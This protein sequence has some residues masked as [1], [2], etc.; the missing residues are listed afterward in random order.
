MK[1]LKAALIVLLIAATQ[2]FATEWKFDKAHTGIGFKVKHM[3]ISTVTGKF[4][5]YDGT[6]KTDGEDF[7]GAKVSFT[8]NINSINTGIEKRD[9]H[10]KSDDFF[11]AK[12]HPKMEFES[13]SF[14][15]LSGNKY[16]L[17]GDLTIRGTTKRIILDVVHNGTVEDP[18]GNTKAG[19]K[20]TGTL[21]RFDFGLKWS[22]NLDSG[23]LVV[24]K[25]VKLDIDV[26]LAKQTDKS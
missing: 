14:R 10:L 12:K 15:K 21:N 7:S 26:E 4:T 1:F 11:N 18:M 2:T 16:Q 25:E 20:I 13:T 9:N 19:F 3:V 8:A 17:V 22:K 23:K 24:G 6:I 5:E